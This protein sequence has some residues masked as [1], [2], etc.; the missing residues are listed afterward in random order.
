VSG[1]S[2]NDCHAGRESTRGGIRIRVRPFAWMR[3]RIRILS[4]VILKL[5]PPHGDPPRLHFESQRLDLASAGLHSSILSLSSRLFSLLRIRIRLFSLLRIPIRLPRMMRIH[6]ADQDPHLKKFRIDEYD[7]L[8][9]SASDPDLLHPG[10]GPNF[11]F[12]FKGGS[13]TENMQLFLL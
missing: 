13:I 10:L 12:F 5:R 4:K 9:S 6:V 8:E 7:R 2:L 11:L 1:T 3:N